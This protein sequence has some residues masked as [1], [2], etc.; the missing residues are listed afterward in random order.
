MDM[1]ANLKKVYEES[2]QQSI[3]PSDSK[4][5]SDLSP[6]CSPQKKETKTSA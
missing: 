6:D 1:D 4:I 3:I 2:L 5:E